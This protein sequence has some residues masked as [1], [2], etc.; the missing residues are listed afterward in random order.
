MSVKVDSFYHSSSINTFLILL[1]MF[2]DII[3]QNLLLNQL[4]TLSNIKRIKAPLVSTK[5]AF[6]VSYIYPLHIYVKSEVSGQTTHSP[7]CHFFHISYCTS[8]K[9]NRQE[10]FHKPFINYFNIFNIESIT[11]IIIQILSAS[12]LYIS[13]ISNFRFYMKIYILNDSQD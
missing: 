3:S 1:T 6:I 8:N 10:N 7:M 11:N 2:F 4:L 9:L 12:S 5:E 13:N